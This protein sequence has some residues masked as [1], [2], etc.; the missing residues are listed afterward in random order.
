MV[1]YLADKM[2]SMWAVSTGNWMAVQ[3]V[4]VKVLSLVAELAAMSVDASAAM[5]AEQMA[6]NWADCWDDLK[7]GNWAL[8]SA[9]LSAVYLV[10][11]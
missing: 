10:Y 6:E 1:A 5:R 4:D 2:A 7:A 3:R 11:Y 9:D 8:H